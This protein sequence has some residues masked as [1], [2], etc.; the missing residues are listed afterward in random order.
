MSEYRQIDLFGNS[1][2]LSEMSEEKDLKHGG[3]IT[4]KSLFRSIH[5]YKKGFYCKNCKYFA[6][7]YYE[8]T[9]DLIG[10]SE[11]LNHSSERVTLIYICWEADDKEEKRKGFYLGG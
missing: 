4:K 9:G 7:T 10:L 5:G 1:I 6:R 11:M 8:Q 3:R 2:A